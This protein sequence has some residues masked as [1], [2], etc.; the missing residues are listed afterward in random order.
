MTLRPSALGA[1]GNG[2]RRWPICLALTLGA[3]LVHGYHPYAEDAGI[4]VPAIKKL[5]D[6]SLY[7]Y[8][9]EFFMEPARWSVF[10]HAIAAAVRVT[11]IPVPYFLLGMYTLCLFFTLAA[12][13]R[14]AEICGGDQASGLLG[15]SLVAAA[16]TMPAAGCALLLSDPY[17]TSRS[18]ST[19]LVLC[20]IV[21]VLTHRYWWAV[22][23]LIAAVAFHPL[24]AAFGVGFAL[25][26]AITQSPSKSRNFGVLAALLLPIG[27]T[28][29]YVSHFPVNDAYR[30][31]AISRS[32]F[33]LTG[34][35]WYEIVGA[36]APIVLFGWLAWRERNNR[37]SSTLFELSVATLWF[38]SLAC[39]GG[40]AVT[41][42]SHLFGLA[43]LQP[44]RAYQLVYILLLV[45]P[46]NSGLQA[47]VDQ[48]DVTR[49]KLAFAT[50]I[51]CLAFGMYVVQRETFPASLHVEWPWAESHNPWQQAYEWIR[52]NTPKDAVFALDANYPDEA[53]NDRQ[54][55]RA[56]AERSALPDQTKDGGIAA[57]FPEL[58]GAWL[59]N[60]A[61]TVD[62]DRA[63][64]QQTSRLLEAGVTWI[65]I[66][67]DRD[68]DLPCPYHNAV[69][70]VCRLRSSYGPPFK[71]ANPTMVAR[72][73]RPNAAR[74]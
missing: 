73:S 56:Q 14:I 43:R 2:Y 41:W 58:A 32:Y 49:R 12:C 8:G 1:D 47:L 28:T 26:L 18:V 64:E 54:G 39:V 33:F 67:Y 44:M 7:P 31:A 13:W 20:G 72:Q 38:A 71:V 66:Q 19:P 11:H 52:L 51:C 37:A 55:F 62:I 27:L 15:G 63:S 3:L 4:Y 68:V 34:W 50:I 60:S 5:I 25:L 30:Q 9:A 36:A 35:E 65:V 17:L 57:L 23:C 53:G 48:W 29:I 59:A 22:V 21:Y 45:V 24:M 6:P 74:R 40:I 70:A 69:V 10:P 16:I 61:L 46:L 42:D